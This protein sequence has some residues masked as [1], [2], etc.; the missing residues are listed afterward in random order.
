[1]FI[2]L[3]LA[4]L[5]TMLATRSCVFIPVDDPQKDLLE[6]IAEVS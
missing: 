2:G 1:M 6:G 4:K 3:N 5:N